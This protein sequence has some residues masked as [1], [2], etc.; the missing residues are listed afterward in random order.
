MQKIKADIANMTPAER[1]S[2]VIK[3]VEKSK[4]S[5]DEKQELLKALQL[6]VQWS[7]WQGPRCISSVIEQ[8]LPPELIAPLMRSSGADDQRGKYSKPEETLL[9]A[10]TALY[11]PEHLKTLLD[12][13]DYSDMPDAVETALLFATQ[14]SNHITVGILTSKA[15]LRLPQQML[16]NAL[17][18]AL[19]R[20]DSG[21]KEF[22]RF[23]ADKDRGLPVQKEFDMPEDITIKEVT[24]RFTP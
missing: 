9:Y 12:V 23:I 20:I 14:C 6:G 22:E 17:G 2:F 15:G 21:K 7:G 11:R 4:I 24:V 5:D 16:D 19:R 10:A 1:A 8:D 3:S 18:E 13:T